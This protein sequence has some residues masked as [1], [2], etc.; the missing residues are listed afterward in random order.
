[1]PRSQTQGELESARTLEDP[2]LNPGRLDAPSAVKCR[3]AGTL[4]GYFVSDQALQRT[5]A[6][7]LDRS[8]FSPESQATFTM[9]YIS[10]LIK[11]RMSASEYVQHAEPEVL[12]ISLLWFL[13]CMR[14][15][16]STSWRHSF[17]NRNVGPRN[18][19][20]CR[21]PIHCSWHVV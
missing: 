18:L 1:M 13:P 4:E 20:T 2:S 12:S 15:R 14:Q 11:A 6:P 7:C 3:Q 16:R 9:R 21:G 17:V 19:H 10:P 8:R 5:R